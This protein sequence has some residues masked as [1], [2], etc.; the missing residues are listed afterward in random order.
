MSMDRVHG[1]ILHKMSIEKSKQKFTD[2]ATELNELKEFDINEM[3]HVLMS[4]GESL[5]TLA[6]SERNDNTQVHG[7]TS[8]AYIQV[9]RGE[10]N[11]VLIEGY[12]ESLIIKG[13]IA[14]VALCY[15]ELTIEELLSDGKDLV[16]YFLSKIDLTLML[17][18]TRV[19]SFGL[20][21]DLIL[22]QA[23]VLEKATLGD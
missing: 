15:S 3:F 4:Y 11:K 19:N 12:T 10:H 16:K 14:M 6:D 20:V 18:P 23:S 17:T 8:L 22:K 13:L 9:K 1:S 21:I 2:Y 5:P 7:C